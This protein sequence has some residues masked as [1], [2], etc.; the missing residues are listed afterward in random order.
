MPLPR[1]LEKFT[2]WPLVLLPVV[3]TLRTV[4]PAAVLGYVVVGTQDVTVPPIFMDIEAGLP[5]T[6]VLVPESEDVDP[7]DTQALTLS[8]VVPLGQ[9]TVTVVQAPQ[10]LPSL[11]SLIVPVLALLFLSAQAR[12]EIV[13]GAEAVVVHVVLALAPAASVAIVTAA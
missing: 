10:L 8:H 12:T 2:V 13:A 9:L 5:R 6:T 11:L 7:E 1:T 4:S 3:H